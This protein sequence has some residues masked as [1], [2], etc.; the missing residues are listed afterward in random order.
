MQDYRM[1]NGLSKHEFD[2]FLVAPSYY[3]WKKTKEWK[4]SREMVIGTCVHSLAIEGRTDYAVGPS[5]DKRTKAGKDEWASFCEE[6]IGKEII[7]PEEEKRI[8][9]AAG[10]A[11]QLLE[12]A[13]IEH[14]EA[15]MYWERKGVMCKGRPDIIGTLDGLPAI[16]DLKTTSDFNKFDQKFWSFGYDIQAAWYR[17]GL[18]EITGRECDFWFLVVDTEEPHFGQW[19]LLSGEAMDKADEKIDEELERFLECSETGEWPEP[20]ARRVLMSRGL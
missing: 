19:V 15:S 5:V 11:A 13:K 6:N 2:N 1:S 8:L 9:G 17:R 20:P 14:V 12:A 7:T 16:I 18:V 3:I 4:P 10:K